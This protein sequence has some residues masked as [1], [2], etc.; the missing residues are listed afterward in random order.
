MSRRLV[1]LRH[2]RAEHGFTGP[3]HDRTLTQGGRVQAVDAGGRLAL[4]GLVP[5]HVICSTAVRTRET[6]D[7]VLGELPTRP[8][9]EYEGSAYSAD[10]DTVFG[11]INAVDPEVGTLLL[12]GHNPTM[13]DLASAFMDDPG[14]ISFPPAS[15]AVV[16]LEVEWLY[17]APGTGSGRVLDDEG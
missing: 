14:L 13:A 10:L 12:V 7:A 9:V 1:I 15:I 5:D 3:D 16:D 8:T 6:L 17:A 2:A 11:L 4:G